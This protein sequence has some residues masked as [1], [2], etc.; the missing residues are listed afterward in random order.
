MSTI[1]IPY[2]LANVDLSYVKEIDSNLFS[3]LCS[4]IYALVSLNQETPPDC[5]L[6]YRKARQVGNDI[7]KKAPEYARYYQAAVQEL[8]KFK[9]TYRKILDKSDELADLEC[10]T[11]LSW[12]LLGIN[13]RDVF[14]RHLQRHK[15]VFDRFSELQQNV[16]KYAPYS[17]QNINTTI[18]KIVKK[19]LNIQQSLADNL[20][21]KWQKEQDK[22]RADIKSRLAP[23][24]GFTFIGQYVNIEMD[25]GISRIWGTKDSI[26]DPTGFV[27]FQ[28]TIIN[29]TIT[30]NR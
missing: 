19:E 8:E 5:Q 11:K 23:A 17:P 29:K 27:A 10:A 3:R 20:L 12:I 14:E 22:K 9:R 6:D 18:D 26:F 4:A 2:F 21:V 24:R 28:Q 16:L 15:A 25:G 30:I 13:R 1:C 7:L